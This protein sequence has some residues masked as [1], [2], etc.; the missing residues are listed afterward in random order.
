[1]SALTSLARA[2]AV[3]RGVAQ[4]I[5]TVGHV[6]VSDRPLVFV[7]LGM[8]GEA[9]APLAAMAGDD[10]RHPRLLVVAQPRNRDERFAFAAGL[11]EVVLP[12]IEDFTRREEEVSAGRDGQ[13]R[14][15]FADAPQILVPNLGGIEFTRLLSRSTRFRR[16]SG[17]YAVPPTVPLLGRWLS[18]FAESAVSPASCLLMAATDMLSRHWATGQSAA[19]DQNL[20]TLI[21]WI[22]PP[23]G[24]RGAEAAVAAE[25]TLTWPP[26]G[27]ATDPSFDNEVL[28]PLMAAY[29]QAGSDR[30]RDRARASL[31]EALTAQLAPTWKLMWRAVSLL[32]AMPPAAHAAARWDADKDAFTGYAAYLEEG[33]FP[34]PR[35]DSAVTAARRLN[36]LERTL[37]RYGA[38]LAFDDPLVMA[39]YRLAGEAFAGTVVAA[40][41]GRIDDT[42][43]RRKLRPLITVRTADSVLLD[44]G[45]AVT[46]RSRPTQ[47]ARIVAAPGSPGQPGEVV[48]ELAGGMGRG[49]TATPGSV[50]EVGDRVCY[51]T[52]TDDYQASAEFPSAE[53]TPWTHGGPPEA[54][55]PADE[56]TAEEWS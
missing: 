12:Y 11:T 36:R 3:A 23:A 55:L 32:R 13:T 46:D 34:Q 56:D 42:G 35:R 6:H 8:A 44:P 21:A 47:K 9:H 43:P 41:P 54:Y 4:P 39:E 28:S 19:E 16:T 27:P 31:A 1:M 29:Q 45:V 48:L 37:A 52:L 18:F 7:P 17:D 53:E 24:Q 50:P 15:R 38:Q 30:V 5:A 20:A 2:Q 10:P 49:L 25:N 40:E 26:A 51:S 14:T 33:G 22:D